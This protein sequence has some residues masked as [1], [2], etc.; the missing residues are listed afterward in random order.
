MSP[1]TL[2]LF[3]AAF[4]GLAVLIAL[5]IEDILKRRQLE[6]DRRATEQA[7]PVRIVRHEP[8][9]G[10]GVQAH[11]PVWT[12]KFFEVQDYAARNNGAGRVALK[13][14]TRQ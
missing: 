12:E 10:Y 6:I 9:K 14:L 3:L 8:A 1:A 7:H 11:R 5:S 13:E 4:L 2:A